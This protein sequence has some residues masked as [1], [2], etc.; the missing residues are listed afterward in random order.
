MDSSKAVK[1]I[2]TVMM[3]VGVEIPMEVDTGAAVSIMSLQ[4]MKKMLPG[5]SMS[6]SKAILRTYSKH[7]IPVIGEIQLEVQHSKQTWKL[8]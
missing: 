8:K 3:I 4:T 6:K 1:P 5:I 7:K 2:I